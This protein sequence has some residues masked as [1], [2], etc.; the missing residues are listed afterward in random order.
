M[1][2]PER[3]PGPA[4]PSWCGGTAGAPAG[5]SPW[6]FCAARLHAAGPMPRRVSFFIIACHGFGSWPGHHHQYDYECNSTGADVALFYFA[7]AIFSP[8]GHAIHDGSHRQCQAKTGQVD[9][10]SYLSGGSRDEFEASCP[11]NRQDR[12]KTSRTLQYLGTSGYVTHTDSPCSV[13]PSF[14]RHVGYCLGVLCCV[15]SA[16]SAHSCS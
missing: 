12:P 6:E 7:M 11:C 2:R 13:L 10:A 14:P 5:H 4:A 8:P 16:C 15:E 1:P 3:Q 9:P